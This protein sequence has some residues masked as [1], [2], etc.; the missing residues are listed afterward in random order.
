MD[1]KKYGEKIAGALLDTATDEFVNTGNT[2]VRTAVRTVL[3]DTKDWIAARYN[4]FKAPAQ[5]SESPEERLKILQEELERDNHY[6][7]IG[8]EKKEIAIMWA[9]MKLGY[10]REETDKILDTANQAYNPKNDEGDEAD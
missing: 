7:S 10:S 2:A 8:M 1:V 3:N 5:N 9:M 4:G 6:I